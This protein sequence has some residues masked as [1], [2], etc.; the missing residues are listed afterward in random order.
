FIHHLEMKL[1]KTSLKRVDADVIDKLVEKDD[2][3]KH[4]LTEDE[5]KKLKEIFEKAI[6]N[7]LMKVE[8]ESQQADGMPVTVTME[9]WMRRMKDMSRLGG[10]MNFYGSMPDSYKVSVNANHKVISKILQA[11]ETK[12]TLM[13]KQAFD[14]ALLSQGMLK[15]A[16]LTAFVERSVEVI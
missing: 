13:A 16:D 15:G 8:I 12:Q 1:E 14:L 7:P 5:S 4:E 2:L 9:E 3:P 11:E 10:G 6:G